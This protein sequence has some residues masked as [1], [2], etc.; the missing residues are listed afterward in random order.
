[1][2]FNFTDEQTMLRESI[3]K[4][5]AAN[6]DFDKRKAAL[7]SEAGWNPAAWAAFAEMGLMAAPLAEAHGGLGG[8]P[9]DVLVIMEEFGKALVT[10]PYVPTVVLG[11]GA[12]ALAGSGAQQEEHLPAIAAGERIMAFAYAEPKG[13]YALNDVATIAKKDGAGFVLNGHKAV[14]IGAPMADT[15]LVSARTGGAQRD[16]GGISL[17]LVPKSAKGVVTRDYPN[18]DGL[19]ASEV[20]FENVA[21][22]GDHLVGAADGALPLIEELGDRAIA[23]LSAEAVGAL[24]ATHELT[25]DYAK[26]RKQFGVPI[27]TFQVLQHR[28]V[29][30]FMAT[31][32]CVSMAYLATLKLD[33]PTV[34]RAKAASA[35]KVQIG[36]A[37][38]FCG[39]NAVQIHGGMGVTEEMRIGHYF[40]R[41][42]MI[43]S[44]FGNVDYHLNR[45]ARLSAEAAAA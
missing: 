27:A 10:E 41:L 42:T 29:D 6:Y 35:A 36:R 25:L 7:K 1:M 2:D 22:G 44:Q 11:A 30:M 16:V 26:N 34:E 33:A 19:R 32:Q 38:R 14:V 31:E 23:A 15:L 17:F 21:L 18:V 9:V 39:Q 24:R 45:Y 28:M 13:R 37:G 40:K 8:G 5:A 20:Y 12:L 4:F 3:A 43:D